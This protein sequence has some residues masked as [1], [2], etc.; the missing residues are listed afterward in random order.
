MKKIKYLKHKMALVGPK[1]K[2]GGKTRVWAFANVQDG[3][4][5]GRECNICDGCFI[6][7]GAVIG[8]NVTLKNG[9]SVFDGIVL[10][11]DVF[12][13]ANAAFVNDRYPRSH[14]QDPWVLE[15]TII[16]KGATIGSNATVLCGVVVGEYA[17]VGAG[18]VV[19][20]SVAPY[21]IIIGNPAEFR[22]YVC[23]CGRKLDEQFRCSCGLKYALG[24]D[25]L[26]PHE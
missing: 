25:G 7:K 17:V 5:I 19:T 9:I 18:C 24:S 4:V 14:R 16:R 1:A 13:G 2:I 15:K 21:T 10:E 23:R 8:N 22:G 6:E 12:C 20:K 11:D 26:K 3:A